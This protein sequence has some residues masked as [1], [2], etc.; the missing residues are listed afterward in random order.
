MSIKKIQTQCLVIV[1]AGLMTIAFPALAFATDSMNGAEVFSVHCAGCH[2]NGGNIV[3]WGKNLKQKT[4]A[5]NGMDSLA[6]IA[7]IV[8]NGKNNM[9]AYKAR[10]TAQQIEDVSAYVLDQAAQGW[11]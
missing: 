6:A 8:T 5:K 10:L 3:R 2:A 7:T 1:L 9:S 11:R 4:L